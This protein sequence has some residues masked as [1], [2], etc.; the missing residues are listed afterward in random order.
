[1]DLAIPVSLRVTG[2][3]LEVAEL[4]AARTHAEGSNDPSYDFVHV[5][6]CWSDQRR[7]ISQMTSRFASQNK[8]FVLSGLSAQSP[9]L[10][11]QRYGLKAQLFVLGTKFND[12]RLE[13]AADDSCPEFWI[14]VPEP[15]QR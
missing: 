4:C 9:D 5:R 11:P 12:G 7:K 1:V 14:F 15:F 6:I 3:V 2:L 10:A 13:I 8:S